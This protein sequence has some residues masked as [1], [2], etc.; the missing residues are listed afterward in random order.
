M[1][2]AGQDGFW[3][4]SNRDDS[5]YPLAALSSPFFPQL[6]I[7][8]FLWARHQCAC[9]GY[10]FTHGVVVRK[11]HGLRSKRFLYETGSLD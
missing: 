1:Q 8:A 3:L 6:P 11:V 9:G 5:H 7:M 4:P 10:A 2:E